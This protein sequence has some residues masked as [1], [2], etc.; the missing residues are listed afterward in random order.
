MWVELFWTHVATGVAGAFIWN[1]LV[2]RPYLIRGRELEAR[3]K[4]VAMLETL[5]LEFSQSPT[6]HCAKR[7]VQEL[8][9]ILNRKIGL[10]AQPEGTFQPATI[11]RRVQ[12]GRQS[13]EEEEIASALVNLGFKK[14]DAAAVASQVVRSEPKGTFEVWI[15][16]ALERMGKG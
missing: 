6:E 1:R 5:A 4:D 10:T 7:I 2:A 8:G 3:M 16:K 13:K 14:L 11:T 12:V 9:H 15:R